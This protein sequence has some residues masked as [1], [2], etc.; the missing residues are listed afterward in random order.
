MER[1]GTT[2]LMLGSLLLVGYVTDWLGRKTPLPRVTFLL[3][4]G[5]LVGPSV[6]D[7]LPDLHRAWFPA[8]TDM[9]LVMVGFLLGER[10]TR[11]FL[12]TYGR[13]VIALSLGLVI[14]T[15]VV[16][17]AGLIA[18]GVTIELALILAG[19]APATDPA[20]TS[21]VVHEL[22]A[23]GRF[24]KTLLG[25]VA[26]DDLWGL[27]AFSLLLAGAQVVSGHGFGWGALLMG[28]WDVGGAIGLGLALGLPMAF[29]TGRIKPGEPTM[30]EALALVF[31]CG[32]LALWLKVS[33]LLSAMVMGIVVANLAAH[34]TRP[35]HAIEGIEWPFMIL[36][37]VLSGASLNVK[38]LPAVGLVGLGYVGW[39]AVGRFVGIWAGSLAC[40]AD[41]NIRR[42]LGAALMPQA[43]VALGAALMAVHRFPELRESIIP[44]VIGAT[45]VF[46]VVGPA[47]TRLAL[48]RVGEASGRGRGDDPGSEGKG[49]QSPGEA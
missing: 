14:G 32:G 34:H 4:F 30:V 10:I 42:W 19:I 11:D 37:F 21:D 18:L 39:R 29:L 46:E 41:K 3:L 40:G 24:S 5:F 48:Y 31:L 16:V 25:V 36:F 12:K 45:V 38:S 1:P 15:A 26:V 43:G 44:V 23:E 28:L 9:A 33:F 7:L 2:L 13:Q 17:W 35:F 22:R 47:L 27:L 49:G 20:A 6:L 8:V